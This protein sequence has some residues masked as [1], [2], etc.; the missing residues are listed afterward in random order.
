MPQSTATF[1]TAELN[2]PGDGKPAY[3]LIDGSYRSK[4]P[5]SSRKLLLEPRYVKIPTQLVWLRMVSGFRTRIFEIPGPRS[6][7]DGQAQADLN[8]DIPSAGQLLEL[9]SRNH[10]WACRGPYVPRRSRI[11]SAEMPE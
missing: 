9:P 10:G 11:L 8:T 4:Q 2:L 5:A 1:I 3:M 6:M 7:R